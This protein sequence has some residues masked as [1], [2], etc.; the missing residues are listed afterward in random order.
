MDAL[1]LLHLAGWT[2][3]RRVDVARD[4]EALRVEGFPIT[5]AA[6]DFL[7]EFSG[8]QITWESKD[9]PLIVDGVVVA[10]DADV[11]WCEALSAAIGSQLVPVGQYAHMTLYVDPHGALWGG[12]GDEYGQVGGSLVDVIDRT[13]LNPGQRLDR[14]VGHG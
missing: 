11:G 3:G 1:T 14:R 9:N 4:L 12:V 6:E 5:S 13:F 2:P 10:R 7:Q 8:L